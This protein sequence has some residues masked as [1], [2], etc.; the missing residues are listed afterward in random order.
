MFLAACNEPISVLGHVEQGGEDGEEREQQGQQ[1]EQRHA[2]V[3]VH[4]GGCVGAWAGAVAW[5]GRASVAE[6]NVLAHEAAN[7]AT[8]MATP[9][10]SWRV[11]VS[12]CL[13]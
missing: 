6:P 11:C 3:V 2:V 4:C 7:M 9:D 10:L 8:S 5:A 12:M 1:P 13:L